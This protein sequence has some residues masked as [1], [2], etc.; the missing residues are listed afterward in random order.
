MD[1]FYFYR[2]LLRNRAA[3]TSIFRQTNNKGADW[4]IADTPNEWL[5]SFI[6][7][8]MNVFPGNTGLLECIE[9]QKLVEQWIVQ[10][11]CPHFDSLCAFTVAPSCAYYLHGLSLSMQFQF[12][13]S[14]GWGGE[15]HIWTLL[16]IEHNT[17]PQGLPHWR[18]L[19]PWLFNAGCAW[20][21]KQIIFN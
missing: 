8:N 13:G 10:M 15:S 1:G 19:N 5:K 21:I 17:G 6:A 11:Q 3:H 2:K 7:S 20:V 18:F 14:D 4:L 16:L 12:Q 9:L